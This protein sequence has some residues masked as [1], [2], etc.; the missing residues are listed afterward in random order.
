MNDEVGKK[1]GAMKAKV[2]RKEDQLM[3]P[4][5]GWEH[6]VGG[7]KWESDPTLVCN[8]EV[9]PVCK[10]V[11]IESVAVS[12]FV[13]LVYVQNNSE[14][15]RLVQVRVELRGDAKKAQGHWAGSYLPVEGK[16]NRGRWVGSYQQHS[17]S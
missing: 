8:R 11:R 13:D 3:P 6:H 2:V 4:V 5:N 1:V 16:I 12:L 14:T 7:G 9:S 17:L 10:E 15:S